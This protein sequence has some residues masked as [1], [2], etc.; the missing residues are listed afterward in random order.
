MALTLTHEDKCGVV[1]QNAYVNLQQVNFRKNT[2]IVILTF[3]IYAGQEQRQ[4][5]RFPVD[6]VSLE[7]STEAF[8]AVVGQF[9]YDALKTQSGFTN[10]TNC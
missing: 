5:D 7:L 4:A 2:G 6:T 9:S 8:L 1:H 3:N 10:A